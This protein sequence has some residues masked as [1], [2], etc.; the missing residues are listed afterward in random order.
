M[1]KAVSKKSV[2]TA[3]L[4]QVFSKNFEAIQ[5]TI[6]SLPCV[7]PQSDKVLIILMLAPFVDDMIT[8]I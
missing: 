6:E 8:L 1:Q 5:S 4:E 3:Y 2:M 7:A